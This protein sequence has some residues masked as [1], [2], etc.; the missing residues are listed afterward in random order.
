[1]N[2]SNGYELTKLKGMLSNYSNNIGKSYEVAEGE[3]KNQEI[4]FF[5]IWTRIT[6][7]EH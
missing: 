2:M 6:L 5:K 1:M 4:G 3:K 7:V